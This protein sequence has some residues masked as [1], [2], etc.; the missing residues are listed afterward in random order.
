L[1][2]VV[3]TIGNGLSTDIK[4]M[5]QKL[6]ELCKKDI[7]HDD[8]IAEIEKFNWFMQWV[9]K[10]RDN[11]FKTFIKLIVLMVVFAFGVASLG[12]KGV[13]IIKWIVNSCVR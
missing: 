11:L 13:E 7:Y 9:N 6:D 1:S 3:K 5:S 2:E 8:H 4:N 10:M 12:S